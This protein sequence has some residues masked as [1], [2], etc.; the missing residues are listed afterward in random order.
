M[1]EGG[2]GCWTLA[3]WQGSGGETF[4]SWCAGFGGTSGA[5]CLLIAFDKGLRRCRGGRGRNWREVVL[6]MRVHLSQ[7]PNTRDGRA[8]NCELRLVVDNAMSS[9]AGRVVSFDKLEKSN[10]KDSNQISACCSGYDEIEFTK[11]GPGLQCRATERVGASEFSGR[12]IR[13]SE[14]HSFRRSRL[15]YGR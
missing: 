6:E 15:Q 4:F 8:D 5:I 9:R 1:I 7:W 13:P 3:F 11:G 10:R 14:H 12:E 2:D